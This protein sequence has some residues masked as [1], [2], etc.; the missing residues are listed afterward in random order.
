MMLPFAI[1]RPSPA[2]SDGRKSTLHYILSVS[3]AES[4]KQANASYLLLEE[5]MCSDSGYRSRV[6][7][8]NK[9]GGGSRGVL[10]GTAV[11]EQIAK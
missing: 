11:V 5:G 10:R 4:S 2:I 9:G 3:Q 7:I 6:A 8:E 1:K